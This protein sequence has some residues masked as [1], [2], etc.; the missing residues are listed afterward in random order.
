MARTGPAE[1][2]APLCPECIVWR[3]D[4]T[5]AAELLAP[6]GRFGGLRLLVEGGDAP[7][8]AQALAAAGTDAGIVVSSSEAAPRPIDPGPAP[9]S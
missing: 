8:V 7:A 1:V 2:A 4:A 5:E 6:V 9:L 3:I